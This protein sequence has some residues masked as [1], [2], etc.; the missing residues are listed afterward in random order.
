MYIPLIQ[1]ESEE[2]KF[3]V[4]SQKRSF[5]RVSDRR[6]CATYGP[7][8]PWSD[9]GVLFLG[10]MFS[11]GNYLSPERLRIQSHFEVL[12]SWVQA[13]FV[14]LPGRKD[15]SLILIAD[16][17][18]QGFVYCITALCMYLLTIQQLSITSKK[19]KA[20]RE[21]WWHSHHGYR[22]YTSLQ[23][24]K[25]GQCNVFDQTEYSLRFWNAKAKNC[26]WAM[27]AAV[28]EGWSLASHFARTISKDLCTKAGE[29]FVSF[30]PLGN[31]A[32]PER[33]HK[34]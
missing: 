13:G 19:I 33:Y 32:V 25:R 2:G 12:W 15:V 18:G 6:L 22:D 24:N 3:H 21:D 11:A 8:N 5:Q 17:D 34:T 16:H 10:W 7:T 28:D 20:H 30:F 23:E 14:L 31:L 26:M 9:C 29:M 1:N 4:V 27:D